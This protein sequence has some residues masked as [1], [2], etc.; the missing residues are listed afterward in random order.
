MG[1]VAVPIMR[2]WRDEIA[3]WASILGSV[4]AVLGL[5]QSQSAV[6]LGGAFLVVLS[7]GTLLYARRH[8]KLLQSASISIEGLNLDSLNI[9][10]LRRRMNRTLVLQRGYQLAKIEG[11]DLTMAWQ[12]DG[13]CRVER[14]T[15]IEF[16]IDSENHLPFEELDCFA[17]D[18]LQDPN[19]LHKIRP[20]LVGSDGLSK[21]IAV[22][23]LKPLGA[24]QP[25]SVLLNCHLSGSVSAG[26]QYYASTVSFDQRVINQ[27]A[28]HLIFVRN[29]PD[30]VRLYQCDKSGR[31][32]LV[33]ELRPFKN[34]G[35]TCEYIDLAENIPGQSV[36]IYVYQIRAPELTDNCS[37]SK[38]LTTQSTF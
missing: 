38:R 15:S 19:R 18:L 29:F 37:G 11:R 33:N 1:W 27:L 16:S 2:E 12:Y 35:E 7:I 36:R 28:V 13:Y 32:H 23:F 20:M 4:V 30:W 14:E 24:Q 21:K 3:T 25:F 34:D 5:I 10:N 31:P 17:F 26:V 22:P 8:R 9:A 6:A